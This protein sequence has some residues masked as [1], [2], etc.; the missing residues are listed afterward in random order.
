MCSC[1]ARGDYAMRLWLNPQKIAELGMTAD[2]VVNAVR[3]QNVQ[4][5]AGVIN[6]PPY[7]DK[8]QL[9]LPIN[10]EGRLTRSRAIRARS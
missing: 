2:D 6:G 9:Q 10:V 7:S 3:R 4:V 5:A 1:S 8:G